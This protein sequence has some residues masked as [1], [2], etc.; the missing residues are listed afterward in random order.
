[1]ADKDPMT[2]LMDQI[3]SAF[4]QQGAKT[5]RKGNHI[6]LESWGNKGNAGR[7]GQG[8][9]TAAQADENRTTMSPAERAARDEMKAKKEQAD[10]ESA[11]EKSRT[12][13]MKGMAKGGTASSRA[14]GI[15]Q[16]GKTRGTMI[17]MC[18]GGMK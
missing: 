13:P 8:G 5:S 14:D 9:P 7:G 10:T 11:Y 6:T 16:R 3:D 18:G 15:A 17:A 2:G 4:K 1:M 12:T